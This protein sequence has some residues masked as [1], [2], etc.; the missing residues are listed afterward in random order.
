MSHKRHKNTKGEQ[1]T[2]GNSQFKGDPQMIRL[3]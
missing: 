3:C 2:T 1:G